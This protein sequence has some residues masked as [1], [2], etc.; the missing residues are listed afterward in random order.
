MANII[1]EVIIIATSPLLG[2]LADFSGAKKRFLFVTY[3]GAV[4]FTLSFGLVAPGQ[5]ALGTVLFIL[6]YVFYGSGENFLNAFLPEIAEHRA[7]GKVSAFSWTVAYIGALLAFGGAVVINLL[8]PGPAGYRWISVWAGLF[9]LAAGAPTF[10]LLRERK[11]A[12]AMPPGASLWTIGFHRL[13]RTLADLRRYRQLFRFMGIVTVYFAGMQVV[14]FFAG[15]I[16]FEMFH[17]EGGK[18]ALFLLIANVSGIIG[19]AVTGR[20]QDRLGTRTTIQIALV[21]WMATLVVS[22]LA[23]REW[24]FWV[25]ANA[26]GL[27][28]GALG[29]ASRVMAGLFSPHHKSGEFFGIYG[30][31]HKCAAILGL[32]FVAIML[33]LVDGRFHLAIGASSVFFLIGLALMFLIDEREGRIIALKAARDHV[34]AHKDYTGR[35]RGD[36]T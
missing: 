30:M 23:T 17:F 11:L 22:A 5:A 14:V 21:F 4:V 31:A 32:G 1:G 24:V 34:R 36:T 19:A 29:T 12:E 25:A 16:A 26:V 13:A 3:V 6:G 27:S 10:L 33:E 20:F 28:M 15:T 8:D 35:I 2:A 7:M 9:F 18:F